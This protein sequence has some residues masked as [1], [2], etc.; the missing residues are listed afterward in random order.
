MHSMRRFFAVLLVL[1]LVFAGCGGGGTGDVTGD[2]GTGG[3]G[4]GGGGGGGD[5]NTSLVSTATDYGASVR[6]A[7]DANED[8]VQKSQG[9]E[10][11][12]FNSMTT[13]EIKA[14]MNGYYSSVQRWSGAFETMNGVGIELDDTRGRQTF[15]PLDALKTAKIPIDV[16]RQV[17]QYGEDMQREFVTNIVPKLESSD[18]VKRAEG[19]REAEL[20]RVKYTVKS[21]NTTVGTVLSGGA[22]IA[23]GVVAKGIFTTGALAIGGP[24]LAGAAAG[25]T[26]KWIWNYCTDDRLLT[27]DEEGHCA[28]TSGTSKVGQPF[29]KAMGEGGTLTIDIPGYAPVTIH[30]FRPPAEGKQMNI[31]FQ[32]I[33]LSELPEGTVIEV[34]Y[35]DIVPTAATCSD[36]MSVSAYPTP[37]DPAPGQSVTVT[38]TVFPVIS[39]CQVSFTIEGTDGYSDS[40]TQSTDSSG[41]AFFYIPGAE[42]DVYDL[43]TVT[44]NGKTYTVSYTF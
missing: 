20:L 15:G 28:I 40:D 33:P 42:E 37:S 36:I 29:P 24:F 6:S 1:S 43:V 7:A 10:T 17:S 16:I 44:S 11:A 27:R 23:A 26:V 9:L 41:R 32:P 12:N 5:S 4:G 38:A 14:L 2:G 25:L 13:N 18:P 3:D 22:A 19:V 35:E 34:D 39:G 21:V 8:F 31:D 30:N